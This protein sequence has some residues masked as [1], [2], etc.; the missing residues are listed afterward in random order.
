[1]AA[2][3]EAA[4]TAERAVETTAEQAVE[5]KM[6]ARTMEAEAGRPTP[7]AERTPANP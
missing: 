5:T 3:E 6:A 7:A 2:E 1:M 4:P